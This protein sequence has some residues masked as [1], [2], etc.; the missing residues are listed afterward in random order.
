MYTK[1]AASRVPNNDNLP[2]V[3]QGP[4]LERREDPGVSA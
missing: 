3:E 1:G 4:R 2:L